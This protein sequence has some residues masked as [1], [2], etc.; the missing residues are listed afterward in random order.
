MGREPSWLLHKMNTATEFAFLDCYVCRAMPT[1]GMD[2]SDFLFLL[3]AA[4]C[5]D[6]LWIAVWYIINVQVWFHFDAVNCSRWTTSLKLRF[7][8]NEETF[9][10]P[11][12]VL[13]VRKTLFYL[14]FI[15]IY[16]TQN[17]LSSLS[18]SGELGSKQAE[19]HYTMHETVSDFVNLPCS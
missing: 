7:C 10:R 3:L 18:P 13:R 1:I 2:K 15:G 9:H 16:S 8:A 4:V 6:F 19:Q 11:A 5:C 17:C 14:K 12:T